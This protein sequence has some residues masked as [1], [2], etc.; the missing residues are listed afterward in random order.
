[1]LDDLVAAVRGK[2]AILFAGAGVS[3]TVGLP[4]WS[5]L[6]EHIADELQIDLSD[7]KGADLNYLTLAEYYR[8]KQGSIGPAGWT[9]TG[10]S[11][12]TP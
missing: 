2:Q 1:V 10:R 11:R 6:I 5:T 9:G 4:S 12:R 3:M 8:L 7:F